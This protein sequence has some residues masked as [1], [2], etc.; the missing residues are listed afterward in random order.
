MENWMFKMIKKVDPIQKFNLL[1]KI[2][3]Q[4]FINP[5]LKSY[6]IKIFNNLNLKIYLNIKIKILIFKDNSKLMNKKL[7]MLAAVL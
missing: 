6:I 4:Y 3:H 2:I 5:F 7:K 1:F